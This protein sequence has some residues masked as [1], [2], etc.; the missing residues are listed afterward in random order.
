MGKSISH[1]VN[2][3]GPHAPEPVP[4]PIAWSRPVVR[5]VQPQVDHGSR[6]AKGTVGERLTVSADAL[7]DGRPLQVHDVLQTLPVAVLRSAD[8]RV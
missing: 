4:L 1:E 2:E 5:A 6:P 7:I 3:T 8:G